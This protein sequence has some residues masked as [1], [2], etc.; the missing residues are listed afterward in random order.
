MGMDHLN[1]LFAE[2]RRSAQALG[3]SVPGNISVQTMSMESFNSEV[4]VWQSHSVIYFDN[5]VATLSTTLARFI[6]RRL[7]AGSVNKSPQDMLKDLGNDPLET[8]LLINDADYQEFKQSYLNFTG[9]TKDAGNTWPDL[10]GDEIAAQIRDSFV[11]FAL[12]HELGHMILE[13]RN[14]EEQETLDAAAQNWDMELDADALGYEF[15][16]DTMSKL[17]PDVPL[18][19]Q[20]NIGAEA[21]FLYPSI[22]GPSIVADS[23]GKSPMG[24]L[25]SLIFPGKEFISTHPDWFTRLNRLR[26]K[27]E[28]GIPLMENNEEPET[29]EYAAREIEIESPRYFMEIS[30]AVYT[31]YKKRLIEEILVLAAKYGEY[32]GRNEFLFMLQKD[33]YNPTAS[34]P[35]LDKFNLP[36]GIQEGIQKWKQG[37]YTQALRVMSAAEIP[38]GIQGE[39]SRVVA[40]LYSYEYDCFASKMES[41]MGQME[42]FRTGVDNWL[43]A[44]HLC[45][46]IPETP[47]DDIPGVVTRALDFARQAILCF[48]NAQDEESGPRRAVADFA[49]GRAESMYGWLCY[50][51]LEDIQ[52]ALDHF[53]ADIDTSPVAMDSFYGRSLAHALAKNEEAARTD[54]EIWE[55]ISQVPSFLNRS[56]MFFTG[57]LGGN[58]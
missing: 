27:I 55:I 23:F 33:F 46:E 41:C 8:E 1:H 31:A 26:Q 15:M 56:W 13:R 10:T 37:Q 57:R 47:G 50:L 48:R 17:H 14:Y 45:L 6:A 12:G 21:F 9:T 36:E 53:T 42:E 2:I 43:E 29:L 22:G 35:A 7:P 52:T 11:L 39:L 30:E 4:R 34:L 51:F 44:Q 28:L 5:R 16:I 19:A 3:Y 38:G 58:T 54:D 24:G 18:K 49:E 40:V 20:Y 25:L 32:E